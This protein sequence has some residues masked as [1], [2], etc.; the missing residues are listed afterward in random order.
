MSKMP[1]T[2]LAELIE[3]NRKADQAIIQQLKNRITFLE[4]QLPTYSLHKEPVTFQ[5]QMSPVCIEEM[6]LPVIARVG[7]RYE[8]DQPVH[9]RLE[10]KTF[11]GW[12]CLGYALHALEFKPNLKS[13]LN[14]MHKEIQLKIEQE[15]M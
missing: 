1:L 11:D 12:K 15:V 14:S 5:Y 8:Q 9:V 10:W 3:M 13:I 7:Y 4:D 6:Q 2:M